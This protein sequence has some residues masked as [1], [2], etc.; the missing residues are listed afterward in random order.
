[1]DGV[2]HGD[3]HNAL[4]DVV[5]VCAE[6][7]EQA[8]GRIDTLA[9]DEQRNECDVAAVARESMAAESAL[10]GRIA[11]LDNQIRGLWLAVLLLA[12][13]VAVLLATK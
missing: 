8:V 2:T 12:I 7:L 10:A 6:G 5:G 11:R 9:A 3:H 13:T 1:M 4:A